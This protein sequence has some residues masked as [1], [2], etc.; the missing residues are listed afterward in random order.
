MDNY[1]KRITLS[2]GGGGRKTENLIKNIFRKYLNDPI[3]CKMDDGAE[4]EDDLIFTTD[5]FVVNPIFFPAG[6]IGRLAVA[7]TV[8]DL[9]SMGA[10]P[11]YMSVGFIIEEGFLF[12]ELEKILLS[13]EKTAIESSVRIVTGDTKVVERGKCDRIF[14]NTAGIGK[15]IFA[16]PISINRIEV[17]DILIINGSLGLHQIAVLISRGEYDI[18]VDIKSDVAPLWDL[19]KLLIPFD[20]KFMRDPTRGGLSQVLNEMV[21]QR[22]FGVEINE[23]SLPITPEVRTVC[24]LLGFE[25]LD[26]ANEG[27]IVIIAKPEDEKEIISILKGHS[28]GRETSGIGKITKENPGFVTLKTHLGTERIIMPPS[29]EILP[30]IC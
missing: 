1:K 18:E 3:L 12:E 20:I 25:P 2:H 10:K 17:G 27:K 11:L 6:N 24:D 9:V 14:I 7:G 26:L 30:R 8:N 16:D 4:I 15:R 21:S 29:G 5:S 19:I 28:L 22:K 23:L 13:I